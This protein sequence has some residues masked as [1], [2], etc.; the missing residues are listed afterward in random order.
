[1]K[2]DVKLLL[3]THI[4]I[5]AAEDKLPQK[6]ADYILSEEN[7]LFFSS[8]SIWEIVI[9]NA[10][11]RPDFHIDAEALRSGLLENDYVELPITNLHTLMVANLPLIHKDPFDRIL[12]AQ[13]IIEDMTLLTSDTTI[14]KYDAKIICIK[15]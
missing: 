5:W 4:L 6:A 3:D 13:A 14:P 15:P 1:L 12:I 2:T 10:L 8:A 9:K 7:V 11:N